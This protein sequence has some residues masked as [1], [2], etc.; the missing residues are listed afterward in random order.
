M[1][2]KNDIRPVSRVPLWSGPI[3][4]GRDW[5]IYLPQSH[6][7]LGF[8]YELASR[9][10]GSVSMRL[11]AKTMLKLESELSKRIPFVNAHLHAQMAKLMKGRVI[12]NEDF[13]EMIPCLVR[14][15]DDGFITFQAKFRPD[16]LT[17]KVDWHGL[18]LLKSRQPEAI[19]SCLATARK[20]D[21]RDFS[22]KKREGNP[23]KLMIGLEALTSNIHQGTIDLASIKWKDLTRRIA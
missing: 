17:C 1:V 18:I 20:H 12:A 16:G 6:R 8:V 15:A 14:M 7:T 10:S 22:P 21:L 5:L 23:H 3:Y 9:H 11:W 4:K 2:S 13:L 19:R